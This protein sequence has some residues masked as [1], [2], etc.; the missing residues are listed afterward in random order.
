MRKNETPYPIRIKFCVVVGIPDVITY[1]NF[2]YD[3]LKAFCVAGRGGGQ[4]FR[5]PIG[6]HRC[7]YNTIAVR[8]EC[9]TATNLATVA[10]VMSSLDERKG[11]VAR[12][13]DQ[14]LVVRQPRRRT[15][16]TAT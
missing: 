7:P 11:R 1:A 9:V 8:R 15:A 6:F 10:A 3:R 13:T 4:I 16:T 14:R 5:F 12:H 2:G